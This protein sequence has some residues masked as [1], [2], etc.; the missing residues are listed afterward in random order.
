MHAS[1][2]SCIPTYPDDF[3]PLDFD[4]KALASRLAV[5]HVMQHQQGLD[6]LNREDFR[7]WISKPSSGL[8]WVDGYELP[9]RPSWLADFAFLAARASLLSGF[10]T[11]FIS[12]SV[13]SDGVGSM[14]TL[15]F[16]QRCSKHLL[17]KYQ[18]GSFCRG[19]ELFGEDTLQAARTNFEVSWKI[20]V[21]CLGDIKA[22][23][24]FIIVEAIDAMKADV[25]N[26]ETPGML[27]QK[28]SELASLEALE[29]KVVKV[30]VTSVK[31]EPGFGTIFGIEGVSASSKIFRN[32]L[33]RISPAAARGLKQRS[34]PGRKSRRPMSS[35]TPTLTGSLAYRTDRVLTEDF[36]LGDDDGLQDEDKAL[37]T[38]SGTRSA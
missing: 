27:L 9:G 4:L 21:E 6:I 14:T 28:L 1:E 32:L 12:N 20:Y 10:E 16:V 19:R 17:E 33:V 22:N 37:K 26:R 8:L 30:M 38:M 34:L 3:I 29:D 23:V 25:E 13:H 36:A 31:P 11:L 24:V 15:T 35:G 5:S 18:A 7:H 2:Q